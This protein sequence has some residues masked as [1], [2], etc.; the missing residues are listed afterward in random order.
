MRTKAHTAT[1]TDTK[2]EKYNTMSLAAKSKEFKNII[3]P[4]SMGAQIPTNI[5]CN[6]SPVKNRYSDTMI[7]NTQSKSKRALVIPSSLIN[8]I[9]AFI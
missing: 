9:E 6:W 3:S 5:P 1:H 4:T 2:I 7:I 8:F